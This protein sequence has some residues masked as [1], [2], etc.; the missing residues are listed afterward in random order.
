MYN[1]QANQTAAPQTT[2]ELLKYIAKKIPERL[3]KALPMTILIGGISWLL[4]TYLLVYTNQGFNPDTWLGKNFLNVKGSLISSTL[5]WTM[6]GAIIP[7]AISFFARGG[8]PVK[9][10]TEMVKMPGNIIQKNKASQNMV[11][12]MILISCG[13]TLLFDKLLSG[14]AGLV[15]GG[16][17]M[18]SVIAFVTGRGS[19]FIQIFRMIFNDVQTFVLKKQKL[20]LDG[21]SVYLIIGSSGIALIVYGIFKALNIFPFIFGKLSMFIPFLAGFFNIILI[22]ILFIFNSVWFILIVLGIVLLTRNKSIPKQLVFFVGFFFAV[23]AAN[24]MLDVN[25]FADDGGWAEAGGTLGGW[26]TSQGAIPAVLSGLPPALGGVVG[27]YVSSILGGLFEG[28]GPS[29]P[30]SVDTALPTDPQTTQDARTQQE[31]AVNQQTTQETETPEQKAERLRI[32]EEKIRLNNEFETNRRIQLEKQKALRDKALAEKKRIEA[33][34]AAHKAYEAG[35]CKKYNTTPDKLMDVLIANNAANQADAQKFAD[36]A[37]NWDYALKAAQGA[38]IVCDAAIDGLAN[39]TG[40]YGKAVRATYK[41][42]QNVATGAAE[43]AVD[44]KSVTA[45]IAS[46]VVKGAV[47]A[48]S[49]FI[50]SDKIKAG[51]TVGAEVIGGAITDGSEGAIKGFKNGIYNAGVGAVTDKIAGKGYGND[52][53]LVNLSGGKT[54]VITTLESGQKL[55]QIVTT[56]TAHNLIKTKLTNQIVQTGIKG[57]S[58]AVNEFGAKP[59]LTKAGVLPE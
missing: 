6:V 51:L 38:V 56:E 33:E 4:H 19:I 28:F 47:S 13:V 41:V 14:V 7:M 30:D 58:A 34:Y 44:G 35:L 45:G 25:L 46:G 10:I 31:T 48:G 53:S 20:R 18:S 32:I 49:D 1:S 23:V 12:P 27:S 3:L 16:I 17:L 42:A 2:I 15:A 22:G 54:A 40:P 11:L 43:A 8:N 55:T 26:L 37:R 39:V 24:K 59:A 52:V 50:Q 29:A 57:T 9:S 5:L 36:R 21:D